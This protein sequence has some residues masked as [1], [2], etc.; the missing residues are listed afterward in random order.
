MT[1][2]LSE[3][4]VRT[5]KARN[6][7]IAE[8]AMLRGEMNTDC[9]VGEVSTIAMRMRLQRTRCQSSTS[10]EG[11]RGEKIVDDSES[12]ISPPL[13]GHLAT[14]FEFSGDSNLHESRW[15]DGSVSLE[16]LWGTK[17]IFPP[18]A[19]IINKGHLE[20]K[21]SFSQT[22]VKPRCA[23]LGKGSNHCAGGRVD[24]CND[25]VNMGACVT[26][27]RDLNRCAGKRMC[28]QT[29]EYNL[30]D[31]DASERSSEFGSSTP[32][33]LHREPGNTPPPLSSGRACSAVNDN[34][35]KR[36]DEL[37][38]ARIP[39]GDS[40][41]VAIR[42]DEKLRDQGRSLG[43]FRVARFLAQTSEYNLGGDDVSACSSEFGSSESAATGACGP[44]RNFTAS[45]V[46]SERSSMCLVRA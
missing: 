35:L 7:N 13:C 31:D 41:F 36:S 38:A 18:V 39:S 25:E 24:A 15:Y 32:S 2:S 6:A 16:S 23:I 28:A 30:G 42:E 11:E 5:Q 3:F 26:L 17:S 34:E 22:P 37:C 40:A 10:S 45:D 4:W 29:S 44:A 27:R 8:S 21:Q 33:L 43:P 46:S 14:D 20:A 12:S 9:V 19:S 1:S